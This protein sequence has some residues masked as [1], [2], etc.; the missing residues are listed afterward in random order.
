MHTSQVTCS[1]L[2][3]V[4]PYGVML[5]GTLATISSSALHA[6]PSLKHVFLSMHGRVVLIIKYDACRRNMAQER[7]GQSSENRRKHIA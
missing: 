3:E 7:F 2:A 1:C 4:S 6:L 5:C